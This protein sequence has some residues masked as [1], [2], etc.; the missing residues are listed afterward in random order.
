MSRTVKGRRRSSKSRELTHNRNLN[1]I[2]GMKIK[3]LLDSLGILELINFS[4][5]SEYSRL[6]NCVKIVNIL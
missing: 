5:I 1:L 4:T 6:E 2:F 3:D